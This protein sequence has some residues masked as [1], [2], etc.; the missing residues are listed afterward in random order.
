MTQQRGDEHACGRLNGDAY[1]GRDFLMRYIIR[2]KFFRLTE[3][4]VIQDERGHQFTK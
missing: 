2:E 1:A 3:D 4:S